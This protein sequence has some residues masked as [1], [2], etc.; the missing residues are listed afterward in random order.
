M[1]LEKTLMYA[2]PSA[3][4][5]DIANSIQNDRMNQA[6]EARLIREALGGQGSQFQ[7]FASVRRAFGGALIALG[8]SVHGQ[9]AQANDHNTVPSTGTLRLAR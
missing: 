7:L 2:I 4:I 1:K 5:F 6:G 9:R 8:Q 3:L